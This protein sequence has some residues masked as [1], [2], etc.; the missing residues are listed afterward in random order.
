MSVNITRDEW[1]AALEESQQLVVDQD[2]SLLTRRDYMVL[3]GVCENTAKR[4]LSVLV[5]RGMAEQRKKRVVAADGRVRVV[6]AWRL[7][8]SVKK[9][10]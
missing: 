1:L 7:K 5:E 10:T 8:K 9:R 3:V 6:Q 4:Q 2:P